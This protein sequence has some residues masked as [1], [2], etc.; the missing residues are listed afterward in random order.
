MNEMIEL[1]KHSPIWSRLPRDSPLFNSD[2]EVGIGVHQRLALVTRDVVT[3]GDQEGTEI[4]GVGGGL[5]GSIQ[6]LQ[7]AQKSIDLLPE[8]TDLLH[9]GIPELTT[10]VENRKDLDLNRLSILRLLGLESLLDQRTLHLLDLI[11]E[12]VTLLRRSLDQITKRNTTQTFHRLFLLLQLN[13]QSL[14]R[15]IGCFLLWPYYTKSKWQKQRLFS[16]NF[17]QEQI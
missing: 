10:H 15:L 16:R 5:F 14:N 3:H 12:L 8:R 11:V 13:D 4:A 6:L 7:T 1:R 9:L 2:A 17:K